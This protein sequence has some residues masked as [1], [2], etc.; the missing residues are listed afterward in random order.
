[1]KVLEFINRNFTVIAIS[2]AGLYITFKVQ[3]C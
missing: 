1:M 2:L 3:E